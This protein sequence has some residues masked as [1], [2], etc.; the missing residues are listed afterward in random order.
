MTPID[1]AR[2]GTPR[3]DAVHIGG[4]DLHLLAL[5][6]IEAS[7]RERAHFAVCCACAGEYLD[8]WRVVQLGRAAGVDRVLT[9][10][11][12]IW[13]SIHAELGLSDAVRTPRR[14]RPIK[15]LT[16]IAA[17]SDVSAGSVDGRAS[18]APADLLAHPG[19]MGASVIAPARSLPRRRPWAS[20]AAAAGVIGLLGGIAIGVGSSMGPPREQVVAEAV[21]DALPGWT[22]NGSARVEESADGRRSVVVDLEAQTSPTTSL[23]EVR[24]LK[25]DASGL[26][27]IG[28]FEGASGRFTIPANVDLTQYP[29]VDVSAEPTDGDP[30]HSGDSIVRGR[31]HAL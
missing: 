10:P 23:R 29:L 28:C 9:P 19:A 4:D 8:L 25:A 22:A 21:L 7:A 31:L 12:G 11:A 27:G 3:I 6:E 20:F 26:V 13:A 24:L 18:A 17:P 1:A 16:D 2:I 30:A 5:S 14:F 15:A